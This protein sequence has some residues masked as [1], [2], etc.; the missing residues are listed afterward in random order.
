MNGE[1]FHIGAS[2]VVGVIAYLSNRSVNAMENSITE[3]KADVK[4]HDERLREH[5]EHLAALEALFTERRSYPR[6]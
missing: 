1:W 2:V 5:G 6:G 3:T 4:D